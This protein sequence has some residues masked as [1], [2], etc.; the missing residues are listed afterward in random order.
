MTPMSCAGWDREGGVQ[1]RA[2]SFEEPA[3]GNGGAFAQDGA[4]ERPLIDF[5]SMPE[6]SV[7][8]CERMD[9]P[10]CEFERERRPLP[11]GVGPIMLERIACMDRIKFN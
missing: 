9:R 6:S 8:V 2:A 11:G 3:I 7:R 5:S 1:C 10:V 4:R